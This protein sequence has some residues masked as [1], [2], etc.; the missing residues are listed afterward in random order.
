MNNKRKSR[1]AGGTAGAGRDGT[2]TGKAHNSYNHFSMTSPR[3]QRI[4]SF[5]GHGKSSAITGRELAEC[6]GLADTREVSRMVERERNSFTPICAT[7]D[8]SNAGY[9]LP[10]DVAELSEY[11]RILK[12][13]IRA[14]TRTQKSI[15]AALERMTGQETV[16]GWDDD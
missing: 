7:C 13:R 12:R 16:K 3:R 5:L 4:S 9:Y 6:L 2:A 14:I 11:N 15:E 8:P 10:A 1:P